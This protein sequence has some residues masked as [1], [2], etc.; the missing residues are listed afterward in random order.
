MKD[1]RRAEFSVKT[2]FIIAGIKKSKIYN[3]NEI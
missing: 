2:T 1:D 3:N